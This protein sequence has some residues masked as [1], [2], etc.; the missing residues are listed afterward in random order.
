MADATE[1]RTTAGLGYTLT[2]A[3]RGNVEDRADKSTEKKD[4]MRQELHY[5]V[6]N[7]LI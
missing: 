7:S 2:M 6:Q 4:D 1:G 3:G 5:L